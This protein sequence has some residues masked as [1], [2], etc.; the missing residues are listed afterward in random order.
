[1]TQREELRMAVCDLMG[2]MMLA[3]G[4][5]RRCACSGCWT[6]PT[7]MWRRF[8]SWMAGCWVKKVG[9]IPKKRLTKRLIWGIISTFRMWTLSSAG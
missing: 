1:M 9:I 7:S 2:D 3:E 4:L 5:L 6:M 8:Y